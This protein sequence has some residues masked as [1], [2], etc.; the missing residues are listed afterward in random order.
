V[1]KVIVA[2]M[3]IFTSVNKVTPISLYNYFFQQ[4]FWQ[5]S[6]TWWFTSLNYWTVSNF[7][8][9]RFITVVYQQI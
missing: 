6:L 5:P 8:S 9:Q 3:H 1:G 2:T 7:S 4:L